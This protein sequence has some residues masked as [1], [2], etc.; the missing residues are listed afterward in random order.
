M[1]NGQDRFGLQ[2]FV[3]AQDPVVARVLHELK[4][5]R[6]Q[7]HWMW[8]V[9]PQLAGLGSSAMAQRYAIG[10]KEE[11]LA[12]LAHPVLGGRL[13]QCTRLVNAFNGRSAHEIFGSPDDVK[14]CS[15]M[16]L[17]H[18]I[19]PDVPDFA[20]ALAKYFGG[21]ADLVTIEKLRVL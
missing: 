16:T 7:T 15:S 10:S 19:A 13:L 17:F 8:F 20:D 18:T 4:E 5:G 21:D 2:R 9:F 12:Y 3:V 14:F 11:A 6:K 1:E